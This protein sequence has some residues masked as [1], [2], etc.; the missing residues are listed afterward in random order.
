M[1]HGKALMEC[2]VSVWF[3]NIHVAYDLIPKIRSKIFTVYL[4]SQI[5]FMLFEP[6]NVE[7]ILQQFI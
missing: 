2:I 5:F 3:Y 6:K 4:K 1:Q 7:E